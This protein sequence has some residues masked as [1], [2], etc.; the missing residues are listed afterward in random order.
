MLQCVLDLVHLF[1]TDALAGRI[2]AADADTRAGVARLI[3][4]GAERR[5]RVALIGLRC[6]LGL[7]YLKDLRAIRR[8][9]GA[10]QPATSEAI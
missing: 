9:D 8:P 4:G 2:R 1:E 5:G 3:R 6:L 10:A 7:F